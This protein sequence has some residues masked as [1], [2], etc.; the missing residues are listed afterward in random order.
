MIKKDPKIPGGK[1]KEEKRYFDT[2]LLETVESVFDRATIA[3]ILQL[4][5]TK[6]LKNLKGVVS[7]GK[8]ARVYWGI[9]YEN[10]DVAV[11]IYY[12]LT[13]EFKKSIW[14][15]LA[16]DPRYEEYRGMNWKKLIYMWTSKEFNN[17]SR[18]YKAE[19]RVPRP[20]CKRNN[21]LVMEFIG[22]NGVRA[23][24]LKEAY[25]E[26]ILDKNSLER[27][28]EEVIE[29][30]KKIVIRARLVHADLSEYNIMI[31]NDK[32]YIIDVSQALPIDHPNALEFLRRDVENISNFFR[33]AGLEVIDPEDLLRELVS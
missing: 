21:V 6:C 8:E 5:R 28:Y 33:E 26:G 29:Q 11:K 31:Y 19:V 10:K 12:T 25:D 7:S 27:I 30:L 23:P 22:S 14:K 2:D 18:M 15:Y 20:I 4:I 13:S 9:D 32:P 24:L 16:G 3:T 1:I 17:L